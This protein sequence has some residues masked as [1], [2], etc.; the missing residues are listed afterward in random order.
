MFQSTLFAHTKRWSG[1]FLRCGGGELPRV[2]RYGTLNLDAPLRDK[3]IKGILL[4]NQVGN[5]VKVNGWVRTVRKQKQIAFAEVSDGSSLKGI[6]AILPSEQAKGLISGTCVQLKGVLVES[7]GKE[8]EKEL[9]VEEIQIIGSCDE[10]YPLQK[11][12]HTFEFLRE[13]PHLRTRTK[14]MNSV[15]RLRNSAILGFQNFFQS[16]DCLQVHTPIITSHDCE[17]GGE[18]FKVSGNRSHPDRVHKPTSPAPSEFFDHPAYLTV[19]GQ[20]HLEIMACAMSRV[21]TINPAFRAEESLTSRHL[22]EFWMLEAEIAFLD[23]LDELLDFTEACIRQTTK[24]IADHSSD[25]LDFFN[26]WVNKGVRARVDHVLSKDFVR[27]TYT[28]AV[29]IL[30]KSKVPFQFEPKWG[31][32]LQSEHEKWLAGEYCNGPVFVTDYPKELKPFYM[33]VNPDG[34]TVSCVDLL[35]P[36]VGELIGGSMREE[37]YDQLHQQLTDCNLSPEEYQWYLDLRKYGTVPHGGFGVG[38]ERYIQYITG[39]ESIRDLI[40]H[41]RYVGHCR[42]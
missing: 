37:R 38:F 7:P 4:S 35:V 39:M 28:E 3:T 18:V 16:Q 40:P 32:G 26:Q 27:M 24:Y 21:Y 13:L 34:K 12:R 17:G 25:D 8:Q 29:E 41:P 6:Q 14:T 22:S 31:H 15:L 10:S 33:R 42:L 19:S 11:K 9:Q 5:Q 20:L 30:Q 36:G 2:R 1:G 23:G